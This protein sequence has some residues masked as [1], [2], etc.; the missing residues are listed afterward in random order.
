MSRSCRQCCFVLLVV[1]RCVCDL[2]LLLVELKLGNQCTV[3]GFLHE[4]AKGARIHD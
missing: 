3:P 4:R 2:V 1:G